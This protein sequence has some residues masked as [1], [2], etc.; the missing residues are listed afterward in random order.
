MRKLI[1]FAEK[2]K[3][4]DKEEDVE[5]EATKKLTFEERIVVSRPMYEKGSCPKVTSISNLF[6][7]VRLGSFNI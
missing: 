5:G 4:K 6:S 7:F 3:K 2:K 1:S